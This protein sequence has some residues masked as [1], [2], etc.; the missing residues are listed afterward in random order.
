MGSL[1]GGLLNKD[2]LSRS[3]ETSILSP[4]VFSSSSWSSFR[5]REGLCVSDFDDAVG[6]ADALNAN[7]TPSWAFLLGHS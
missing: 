1:H 3:F 2:C 6:P 7:G 4:K 5:S